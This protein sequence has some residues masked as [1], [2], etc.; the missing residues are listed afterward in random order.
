MRPI[1]ITPTSRY[2]FRTLPSGLVAVML[3]VDGHAPTD[4]RSFPD[5]ATARNAALKWVQ[6]E[7]VQTQILEGHY[8]E[9]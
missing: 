6:A 1:T 4:V 7:Q 2:T 8:R 3:D 5:A 9:V